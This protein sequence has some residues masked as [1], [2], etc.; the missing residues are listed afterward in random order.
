MATLQGTPREPRVELGCTPLRVA[1]GGEVAINPLPLIT[2]LSE[3][4][5]GK[6]YVEHEPDIDQGYQLTGYPADDCESTFI[7]VDARQGDAGRQL[8]KELRRIAEWYSGVADET[9][10]RLPPVDRDVE[11]SH[12]RRV[13]EQALRRERKHVPGAHRPIAKVAGRLRTHRLISHT[14]YKTLERTE[15]MTAAQ[16]RAVTDVV[17]R[18]LRAG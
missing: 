6:I 18:E 8:I 5:A 17:K 1:G 13:M 14:T 3:L 15:G 9:E 12:L 11:L 4:T 2:E 10:W 7:R 16:V